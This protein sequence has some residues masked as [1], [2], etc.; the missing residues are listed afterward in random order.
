MRAPPFFEDP[1]ASPLLS[2]LCKESK[3]DKRLIKDLCALVIENSGKARVE[4]IDAEISDA[5]DRCLERR[6]ER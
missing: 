6:G 1:E 3:V 4:G 5:L 2:S